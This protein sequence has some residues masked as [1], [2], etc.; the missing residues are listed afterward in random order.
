MSYRYWIA[1]AILVVSISAQA[2]TTYGPGAMPWTL[3]STMATNG[4]GSGG[5]SSVSDGL[6]AAG[7]TLATATGL[8]SQVNVITTASAGQGVSLP[9]GQAIGQTIQVINRSGVD[10]IVYPESATSQI[11]S[12][13]LGAGQTIGTN[14]S[15]S[16][17][18][19]SATEWRMIP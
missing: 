19:T 17:R 4:G 3:I 9:T 5:V 18:K 13:G 12:D 14:T 8:T 6:S 15:P 10:L 2:Q 1:G 16:F 11:E 7:S